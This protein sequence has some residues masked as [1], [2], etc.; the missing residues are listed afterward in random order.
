MATTTPNFGWD[1]PQSTDLVK[2]GATAIAALGNDIDTSLVDL[3]GGTTGQVLSKNSNTDMDFTWTNGGDITE[4]TAGT[5]ISGGGSSGAVT[6]TNSMATEITASG[7]IIVG[8]GSGTFDNLP[9]GTTGQV[10][11]ADTTV[12]PYK[13]KWATVAGGGMT[14]ISTTTLSGVSVTLSSIP[15]TYNDLMLIIFGM[16]GNTANSRPRVLPNNSTSIGFYSG[17]YD[18]NTWG[19]NGSPLYISGNENTLRTNSANAWALTIN[20]YASTTSRKPFQCYGH[21]VDGGG[22]SNEASI[23]FQGILGTT[24]AITSI[25]LDYGN[26]NSFSA[27]TVLLYGVK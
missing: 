9:I 19:E 1:I 8:T 14:L 15:G 4:V 10:L 18:S 27:G 20:N 3:K 25:V 22:A 13:V 23:S 17:L 2:D 24:S 21:F 16:T 6:I 26:T 5:G 11:T 12:S 7:D